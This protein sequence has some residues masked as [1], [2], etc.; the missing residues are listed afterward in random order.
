MK[1]RPALTVVVI[2]CAVAMLGWADYCYTGQEPV[3]PDANILPVSTH[4]ITNG[5]GSVAARNNSGQ[6]MSTLHYSD[7]KLLHSGDIQPNPGPVSSESQGHASVLAS[8]MPRGLNIGAWNGQSLY[9]KIEQMR[10]VL[11]STGNN[12]HILGISDTWLKNR[13]TDCEIA[14]QGYSIEIHDRDEG[15]G[16]GGA[17]YIHDSVSYKRRSDLE[18]DSLEVLVVQVAFP[19]AKH[20]LITTVY[21]PSNATVAWY[22]DFDVFM[23]QLTAQ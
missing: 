18:T 12:V 2:C 15:N 23:D 8:A 11:D 14:I 19:H 21:R 9:N 4:C 16:G 17:V 7:L 10:H 6:L 3:T 13:H 1:P 5:Q 20:L 22:N